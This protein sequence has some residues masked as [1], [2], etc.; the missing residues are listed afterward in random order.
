VTVVVVVVTVVG[1]VAD[2]VGAAGARTLW[3]PPVGARAVGAA[4]SGES[5]L[6]S[7]TGATT[8]RAT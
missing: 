3:V 2:A 5:T 1:M 8:C 6:E 4:S 7:V